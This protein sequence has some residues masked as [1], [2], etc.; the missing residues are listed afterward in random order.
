MPETLHDLPA[1][2]SGETSHPVQA[3]ARIAAIVAT[4][5]ASRGAFPEAM[6]EEDRAALLGASHADVNAMRDPLPA[7]FQKYGVSLDWLWC[8]DVTPLLIRSR[9]ANQEAAG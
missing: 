5:S 2:E 9:I 3:R 8:G 7:L 4:F 1:T 6:P